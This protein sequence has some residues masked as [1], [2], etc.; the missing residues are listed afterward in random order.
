MPNLLIVLNQVHW[1]QEKFQ[2]DLKINKE[3]AKLVSGNPV[4]EYI[5]KII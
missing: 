1:R 5:D 2:K 3:Y 4:E